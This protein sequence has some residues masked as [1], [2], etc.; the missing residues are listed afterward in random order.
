M[1]D[2][3]R[4]VLTYSAEQV[5][6]MGSIEQRAT[7]AVALVKGVV[8]ERDRL[9]ESIRAAWADAQNAESAQDLFDILEAL[10]KQVEP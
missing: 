5:A 7:L 8:E 10:A 2:E 3:T 6:V 9:R 1:S 4:V